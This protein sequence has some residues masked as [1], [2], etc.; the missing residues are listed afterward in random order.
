MGFTCNNCGH[1]VF[2]TGKLIGI[3]ALQS[4]DARTPFGGSE[5][6]LVFCANCG[7]GVEIIVTDPDKIK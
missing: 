1:S 7:R 5:L 3:A 2:K 6:Q 4:L